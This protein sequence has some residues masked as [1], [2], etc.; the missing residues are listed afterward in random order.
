MKP[1][2]VMVRFWISTASFRCWY[3]SRMLRKSAM[4]PPISPSFPCSGPTLSEMGRG[5]PEAVLARMMC[6]TVPPVPLLM[7]RTS[8]LVSSRAEALAEDRAVI[9]QVP[10]HAAPAHHRGGVEAGQL[11]GRLVPEHDR[12]PIVDDVQAVLHLVEEI[13]E[14]DLRKDGVASPL[15][16]RPPS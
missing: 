8:G 12:P 2:G 9:Q 7:Q 15:Y 14:G 3:S 5:L 4:A 13:G 10:V 6:G 1:F 16:A 11:L